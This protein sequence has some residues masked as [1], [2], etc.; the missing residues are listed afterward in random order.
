MI[1]I[2]YLIIHI[3]QTFTCTVL[4]EKHFQKIPLKTLVF[5]FTSSII[6]RNCVQ[7]SIWCG[8]ISCISLH[9]LIPN[10]YLKVNMFF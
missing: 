1:Q 6:K 2:S 5:R 3:A 9:R 4:Q 8:F 10:L 7:K